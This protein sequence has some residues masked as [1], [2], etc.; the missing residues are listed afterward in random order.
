MNHYCAVQSCAVVRDPSSFFQDIVLGLS[1]TTCCPHHQGAGNYEV[2]IVMGSAWWS[3]C[4][5]FVQLG[6]CFL[7]AGRL[8]VGPEDASLE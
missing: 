6:E 1:S 3:R 2:R 8:L 7:E 4:K 5:D